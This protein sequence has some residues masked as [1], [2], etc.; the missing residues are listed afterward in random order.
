MQNHRPT[1]PPNQ[2]NSESYPLTPAATP[3][4]R[5]SQAEPNRDRPS[6]SESM[7]GGTIRAPRQDKHS[8]GPS[9]DLFQDVHYNEDRNSLP[10]PPGTV[11]MA[12]SSTFELGP[13]PNANFM[14][15]SSLNVSLSGSDNGYDSSYYSPLS[16]ALS[17]SQS[18]FLSSPEMEQL[19]LYGNPLETMPDLSNP[20][21]AAGLLPSSRSSV[22][23]S[24]MESPMK[25]AMHQRAMSVP[26]VKLDASIEDTGI[27][28]DD[29]STFIEG[30]DPVDGK[31]VCLFPDCNKKFGRKENIKSHVQTHLGD[32]Q[33]RCNHCRKCFVRQHDLKRHAKIHSG[34]KPYPCLCGNSFARHDALTRHRQRG[35]CIGAFEGVVKKIVKRGRPR[36][37]RP[38]AEERQEKATRT[39]KKAIAMSQSSSAS[40]TSEQWYD[41]SSPPA[42][43]D[44]LSSGRSVSPFEMLT[45]AFQPEQPG[46]GL[47]GN[48]KHTPPVSPHGGSQTFISPQVIQHGSQPAGSPSHSAARPTTAEGAMPRPSNHGS[49]AKSTASQYNTPPDLYLSSSSPP[50]SSSRYFDLDNAS[51]HRPQ[52]TGAADEAS[53]RGDLADFGLPDITEQ[54]DEMFLDFANAAG[55]GLTTLEKDPGMLL[56]DKFEDAF[57]GDNM[58]QDDGATSGMFF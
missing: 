51:V 47:Q 58:F 1:T 6:S 33:Y 45:Q 10:S 30:P 8:R 43:E 55:D 23:L 13:M 2:G 20:A 9:R 17:P 19:H 14:S 34:V 48:A 26:D 22:D 37:H 52:D 39:R 15:M 29:I 36:K 16:A 27:T 18:S 50:A 28:L 40:G 41:Q 25:G 3:F 38:E 57:G 11:P 54:V 44:S 32:R 24:G 5:S 31:W 53:S 4:A 49:P 56:M 42:Y 46:S 12:L 35:M 7:K 21:G